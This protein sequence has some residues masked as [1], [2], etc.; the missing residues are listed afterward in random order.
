ML[1]YEKLE[2]AEIVNK[3]TLNVRQFCWISM[4]VHQQHKINEVYAERF[5]RMMLVV[6]VIVSL[7]LG[8]DARPISTASIVRWIDHIPTKRRGPE[9][10]PPGSRPHMEINLSEP[11]PMPG[12]TGQVSLYYYDSYCVFVSYRR[13]WLCGWPLNGSWTEHRNEN[14]PA[15]AR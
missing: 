13:R 6:T 5:R 8:L 7:D 3:M 12:W 10:E 4:T 11:K 2:T 9:F 14:L 15:L 1:V